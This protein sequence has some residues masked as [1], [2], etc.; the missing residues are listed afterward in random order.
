MK[1]KFLFLTI[2]ISLV[3]MGCNAA[4]NIKGKVAGLSYG[5]FFYQDG[6]LTGAYKADIDLVWKACEKSVADLKAAHIEKERKISTGIMKA[7][8]QDEQVI[9]KMEYL[10]RKST[11][12]SVFVGAFGNNVASRLIHEKINANLA[13]N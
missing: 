8:I 12:V 13:T 11:S 5:R 6:S 4:V 7:V 1:K 9:I 3:F 2:F 10:G